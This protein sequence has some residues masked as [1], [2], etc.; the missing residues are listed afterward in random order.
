MQNT[1]TVFMHIQFMHSKLVFVEYLLSPVS[2][3]RV[4]GPS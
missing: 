4:D 2:T 1:F 3:T